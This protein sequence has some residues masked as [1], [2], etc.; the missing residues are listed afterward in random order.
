VWIE[1]E[2]DCP[3]GRTL[4][5]VKG[6]VHA[7]A[8]DM[9]IIKG[10]NIYPSIIEECVRS[11]EYLSVEYRIQKSL[12]SATVLVEAAPNVSLDD[13]PQLAKRLQRRIKD[14]T[15]VNLDVKVLEPGKLPRE[16][17]K[18]KRIVNEEPVS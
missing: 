14:K 10:E 3:C 5:L 13:Y 7:R 11:D 12:T 9:I 15:Y 18:T 1:E 17:A 2:H 4:P 8:D 16:V 6:G